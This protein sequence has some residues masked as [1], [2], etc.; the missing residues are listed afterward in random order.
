MSFLPVL[1]LSTPLNPANATSTRMT[2]FSLSPFCRCPPCPFDSAGPL[3]VHITF[4]LPI[5][6]YEDPSAAACVPTWAVMRRNSFHLRPSKR[7]SARL[8]VDVSRGMLE[9]G[10]RDTAGLQVSWWG[11]SFLRNFWI[12]MRM[13]WRHHCFIL[14]SLCLRVSIHHECTHCVRNF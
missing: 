10:R 3:T 13:S 6:R 4:V 5:S 12:W 7:K 1:F 14:T 9:G 2:A 11:V 8:Y